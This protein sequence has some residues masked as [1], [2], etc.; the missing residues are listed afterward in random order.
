MQNIPKRKTMK[1]QITPIKVIQQQSANSEAK[2]ENLV[3]FSWQ[4]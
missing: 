2:S 3:P 4:L 1:K